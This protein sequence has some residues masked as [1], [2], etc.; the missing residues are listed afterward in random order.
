VALL[1]GYLYVFGGASDEQ[2]D[3]KHAERYSLDSDSWERLPDL[4]AASCA[5]AATAGGY[6][7]VLLWGKGVYRFD[8]LA[9]DGGSYSKVAPL[10]LPEWYGFAV[11]AVGKDLWAFGGSTKG[12][13]TNKTF[14]FDTHECEWHEQASMSAVR[15][16]CAAAA[17][18]LPPDTPPP[19]A[20][21]APPP[22]AEP[23]AAGDEAGDLPEQSRE[24]Q[25]SGTACCEEEASGNGGK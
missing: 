12:R 20:P 8:H 4:P 23:S 22:C 3:I 14:K 6:V 16:R 25:W 21:P 10:P 24:R 19:P 15:R 11:A 18:Y 17:I 7:H 2:V 13:W 1:E 9:P 5:C